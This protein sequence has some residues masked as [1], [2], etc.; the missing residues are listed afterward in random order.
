MNSLPTIKDGLLNSFS[1]VVSGLL[2][3]CIESK[4]RKVRKQEEARGKPNDDA[5]DDDLRAFM[6]KEIKKRRE[7]FVEDFL[8]FTAVSFIERR[9]DR[10]RIPRSRKTKD[11]SIIFNNAF[12]KYFLGGMISNAIAISFDNVRIR[13]LAMMKKKKTRSNSWTL[14]VIDIY[15]TDGMKGF[16]HGFVN[17]LPLIVSPAINFS[18]FDYLKSLYATKKKLT[19]LESL[20]IGAFSKAIATFV[21]FPL[22]RMRSLSEASRQY[23]NI[24]DSKR[25]ELDE[26]LPR[27]TEC[28]GCSTA[29]DCFQLVLES[30]GICGLY[31]GL[32][33]HVQR[34]THASAIFF[35]IRETL[36]NHR[37]R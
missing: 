34:S 21:T 18:T 19:M 10:G 5:G 22:H 28:E 20:F 25:E 11:V 2:S 27:Q 1:G 9:C 33:R 31:E 17:S 37:H 16:A 29:F 15:N 30:Q 26:E 6:K 3:E 14:A 4:S 24:H 8:F 35:M 7:L 13:R 32:T 12:V 23:H 36:R